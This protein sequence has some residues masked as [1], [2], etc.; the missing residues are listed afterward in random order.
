MGS[1]ETVLVYKFYDFLRGVA[2]FLFAFC[3]FCSPPS[4]QFISK[5]FHLQ[6]RVNSLPHLLFLSLHI[7]ILLFKPLFLLSLVSIQ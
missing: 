1:L 7:C 2:D 5:G 6:V 3:F 4:P